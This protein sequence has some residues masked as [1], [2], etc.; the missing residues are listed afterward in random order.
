METDVEGQGL[1]VS[2]ERRLQ[3]RHVLVMLDD[4]HPCAHAVSMKAVVC[5][6]M[7]GGLQ[8]VFKNI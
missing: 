8:D 3:D 6:M 1:P 4:G 7:Q 5:S 2:L